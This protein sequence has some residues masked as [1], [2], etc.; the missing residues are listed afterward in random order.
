MNK[1]TAKSLRNWAIINMLIWFLLGMA[2]KESSHVFDLPSSSREP[3][4]DYAISKAE[5][6]NNFQ[7]LMGGSQSTNAVNCA[8]CGDRSANLRYNRC[9]DKND[10]LTATINRLSAKPGLLSTMAR[11]PLEESTLIKPVCTLLGMEARFNS[12]SNSFRQCSSKG[13]ISRV[14]R[15]CINES[16]FKL[17]HNSFDLV[18]S[19]MKGMLSPGA[20]EAEQ[21]EDVRMTYAMINKESGFHLNAASSGN[22]SRIGAGGIGQLTDSAIKDVNDKQLSKMRAL[23]S[24][25]D[26]RQCRQLSSEFLKGNT[27]MKAESRNACGRV[28]IEDG[29]PIKNILYTYG[30]LKVNK[31]YLN[32]LIFK[33]HRSKFSSLS[34]KDLNKIQRAMTVWAHNTGIGGATTPLNALLN[35]VYRNKPVTNA[36]QFINEMGQFLRIAP[37]R[38]NNSK[39]RIAET[40]RYFP[41]ITKILKDIESNVGGGSCLN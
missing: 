19:C 38:S 4:V 22:S 9:T 2:G 18:S 20:S 37:N 29:N 34:A 14:T 1:V 35:G 12:N 11:K 5:Q 10:Y 25:S 21:K 6:I 41:D 3:I 40:T 28:A 26:D 7:A 30:F 36:N 33:K 31:D 15:P 27:P 39:G 32:T 23:L 17:A 24:D 16:Y 13:N 8:E